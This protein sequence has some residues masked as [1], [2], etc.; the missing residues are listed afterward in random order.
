MEKIKRLTISIELQQAYVEYLE[1]EY[2]YYTIYKASPDAIDEIQ[3]RLTEVNDKLD[4]VFARYRE[5]TNKLLPRRYRITKR[6]PA[7]S[8]MA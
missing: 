7:L 6:K 3:K 5:E 8:Y 4:E 2:V 1:K